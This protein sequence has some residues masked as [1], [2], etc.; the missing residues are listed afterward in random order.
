MAFDNLRLSVRKTVHDDAEAVEA[1][2][3]DRSFMKPLVAEKHSTQDSALITQHSLLS[4][5]HCFPR[6]VEDMYAL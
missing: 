5:Q 3:Y 2:N 6:D 4:T 1:S